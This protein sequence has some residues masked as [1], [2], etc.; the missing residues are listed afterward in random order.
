MIHG[1]GLLRA[2]GS[3]V[4]AS[5]SYGE[6]Y[7]EAMTRDGSAM[8]SDAR[9][10]AAPVHG[11]DLA[12]IGRRYGIAPSDLLDFSANLNPLGP[13]PSLLRELAAA[14]A[15]V[16]DLARYPD[17]ESRVL[18]DVLARHLDIEPDTIVIAN[19]AAA[20]FAVALAACDVR[21]CVVP[22]PA[23]SEYA[24]ALRTIGA[25]ERNVPLDPTKNFA[26]DPAALV[27]A[28]RDERAEA[29]V[30]TN[31]H[32][33]SGALTA[34]ETILALDSDVRASGAVTIADEAFVEYALEASITRD[35]ARGDGSLIAIRSLTKFFA[36]PAL[37]VGYAVTAPQRSRRMRALLPSWPVTTLATRALAA[38][39]GD[40]EFAARSLAANARAREDLARS[41]RALGCNVVP[42]TANFL[43]VGL[44]PGAPPAAELTQRMIR[45][46]LVVVRDC[47]SYT[48]LEAGGYIRV[49]I[50]ANAENHRLVGALT[51]ALANL[52][53]DKAAAGSRA[54]DSF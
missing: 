51:N 1:D 5:A 47:S 2:S 40:V 4:S 31:P 48:G 42:S 20:L 8:T 36:V 28:I 16:R 41:L 21:R 15:D 50:R 32:N 3:N 46:S 26:L 54:S 38:A 24:H 22:T 14:A 33:P 6:S 39:L 27:A 29:L 9:A 53:I 37:R 11:G 44:P 12:A 10:D 19:G 13:P 52:S 23:F 45:D 7:G 18:R 49:A 34:R 17:P 35:A 25:S 43:L 30:V